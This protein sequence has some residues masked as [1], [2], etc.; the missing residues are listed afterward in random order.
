MRSC[1]IDGEAIVTHDRGLAVF[2][3]IRGHGRNGRQIIFNVSGRLRT[4][5][6]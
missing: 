2:D 1:L 6:S 3:L 4:S 5:T